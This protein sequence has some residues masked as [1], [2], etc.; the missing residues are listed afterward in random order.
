MKLHQPSFSWS[1]SFA[2]VCVVWC[3]VLSPVSAESAET[4]VE[5]EE[6]EALEVDESDSIVLFEEL[7]VVGSTE[8]ARRLPGSAHVLAAEVLEEQNYSDIHRILRQVPG[9]NIQ[10]EDGYGLRPNIGIRGTGVERSSKI[11]MMEDGVLIAPAPYAASSAY[12]SP[13]AGRMQAIE[14]RKGSSSVRHGPYT[15]GG[16]V[17]YVSTHIPLDFSANIEVAGGDDSLQRIRASIGDSGPRFGWLAE[18][19]QFQTDGF[20]DLDDG[21]DTGVDLEDYLL[22]FRVHSAPNASIY[23]ALELK[24]GRTEQFGDETYLGLSQG[25][26]DLTPYRRYVASSGDNIDT[27]HEQFQLRY[28]VAP[29]DRVNFTATL[30]RNDFFRNWAKLEKVGGVGVASVL[31]DPGAFPGLFAILRGDADSEPG[32]L[33]VRN[34]RRD[35]YSEGI[36]GVL[37]WGVNTGSLEHDLDFGFRIHEDQEDRFQEEDEYQI[38]GGRRVFNVLGAPGSNANRI[39]DAESIAFFV[40]DTF[41][42]GDWTFTPGVRFE[43][44]DLMRQDFGKEDPGRAGENLGLREN[45][46]SEVIP[47]LGISYAV[48]D[49]HLIIGGVHR[50]FSPPSPSSTE[51][52]DAEES[53]NYEFGWR[54]QGRGASAGANAEI[55]AFFNDYDNLLGADTVS[56]GGAGTGDQFNGGEVEVRGLEAAFGLDLAR[57]NDFSVPLRIVYTHTQGEFQNSF[58]SENAD[59]EPFVERGDRLPYIPENQ[60]NVSLGFEAGDWSVY[61]SGDYSD[62]MRSNAGRGTVLASE[63]IDDRFLIDLKAEYRLSDRFTFWGQLLNATDEIYVVARRPAGLRPGRPRAALFGISFD[64]DGS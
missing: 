8:A 45:S 13:T 23:Q 22:K 53:L 40:E 62:E 47:G 26:F 41:S 48:N 50:G 63:R 33:A 27:E 49:S 60:L 9:L 36:Q 18:T 54:W 31:D 28:Y 52:V 59:W 35:Y 6:A 64:F 20:K 19:Y 10:E 42:V 44:I 58:E 24:M 14:V 34:N 3:G 56:G 25:D 5:S 11:T 7:A 51:E 2:A 43:E 15:T 46:L 21:G 39:A 12:Y 38:L 32:A 55:V 17:N 57:R 30:Y 29:N 37:S 4:P 61:L 16:A 1:L